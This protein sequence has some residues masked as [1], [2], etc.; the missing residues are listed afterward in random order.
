MD[1][2]SVLPD[3][4]TKPYAHIIPPLERNRISTVDLIT[5]DTL[6]IAR[7]AHVPPADVRRLC[8]QITKALH[9][10]TGFEENVDHLDA[11]EPS[12]SLNVDIPVFLGPSTKLNL[13]QWSSISTL[14][15]ALDALL[16]G[17]IPT[18]YLTE[19]TGERCARPVSHPC[20]SL[21]AILTGRR[22]AAR[23]GRLSSSSPYYW[24]LSYPRLGAS[25][26]ELSTSRQKLPS[27][28]HDSHRCLNFILICRRCR[29]MPTSS[30]RWRTSSPSMPWIS[31]PKTTS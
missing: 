12:S 18:G 5:L 7:R 2:S 28:R 13:S 8:A 20:Y 26:K 10:D 31:S 4:H 1:L 6:E 15:P 24:L 16:H 25:T 17:G 9:H 14:D 21:I 29:K 19:V 30:R 3:F 22:D 27:P 23:A 11:G